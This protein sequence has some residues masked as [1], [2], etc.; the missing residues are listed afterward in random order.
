[1][2]DSSTISLFKA[3]FSCAGREPANGKRKGGIKVDTQIYL[4]EK[5]PKMI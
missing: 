1:M 3:I 4:Q 5:I 2:I